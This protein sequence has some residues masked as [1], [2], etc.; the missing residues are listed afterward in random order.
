M[1]IYPKPQI[2]HHRKNSIA[3]VREAQEPAPRQTRLSAEGLEGD[4]NLLRFSPL[5][6]DTKHL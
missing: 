6:V 1:G 5:R 4:M 3:H 2:I